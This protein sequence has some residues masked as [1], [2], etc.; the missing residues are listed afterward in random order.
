MKELL[1]GTFREGFTYLHNHMA[2]LP[3]IVSLIRLNL[4]EDSAN[5]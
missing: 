5:L 2:S 1:I 4:L 3:P